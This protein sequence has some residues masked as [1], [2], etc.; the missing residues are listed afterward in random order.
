MLRLLENPMKKKRLHFSNIQF[1]IG[2]C[3]R[4]VPI[5]KP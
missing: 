1:R 5:I 2:A 4:P 3:P